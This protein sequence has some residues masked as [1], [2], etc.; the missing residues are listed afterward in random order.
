MVCRRNVQLMATLFLKL[1]K[2]RQRKNGKL[3]DFKDP[4]KVWRRPAC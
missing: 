3:V 4:T 1:T 2:I